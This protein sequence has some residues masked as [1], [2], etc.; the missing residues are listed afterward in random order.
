MEDSFEKGVDSVI[1]SA[2]TKYALLFLLKII[3]GALLSVLKKNLKSTKK[4]VI[5]K[6]E[7]SAQ[8]VHSLALCPQ[9]KL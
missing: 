1:L 8:T 7:L 5:R 2:Y 6:S 3:G 4:F 9:T